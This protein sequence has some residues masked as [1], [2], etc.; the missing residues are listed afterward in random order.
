[1]TVT[2]VTARMM[3]VTRV[4]PTPMMMTVTPMMV[5]PPASAAAATDRLS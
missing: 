2:R 5:M 4:T 3:T 1:M